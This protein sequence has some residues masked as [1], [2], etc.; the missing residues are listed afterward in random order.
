M[1]AFQNPGAQLKQ[2]CSCIDAFASMLDNFGSMLSRMMFVV[3]SPYR[4]VGWT[5]Q[6]NGILAVE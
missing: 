1:A 2:P 4:I 5:A 6:S 3:I